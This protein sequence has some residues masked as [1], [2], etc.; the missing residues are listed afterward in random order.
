MSHTLRSFAMAFFAFAFLVMAPLARAETVQPDDLVRRLA[1]EVTN[2]VRN[3]PELQNPN[4]PK[5]A[6]I[7][8]RLI[9]PR[10]DFLRITQFAMGRNWAKATPQE[11]KEI[12][13]QFSRLLTRT[14]SNAIASLKELDIEVKG[15]KANSNAND[16]TV[17]TQ[18]IGRPQPVAIDYSL[19]N[20]AAGWKVYDVTVEGISL[21]A[22]YRD[23]F[24]SLVSSSGVSGLIDV[25]KKK[26]GE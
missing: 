7:V 21:I 23:E 13:E 12:V 25:L 6:D 8:G 24:G 5:I 3:D 11:Q 26:N 9:V 18:M 2:A 16:V 14:Y 17:K 15:T 4:S 22:A 10:F 20:S 19:I 1:S